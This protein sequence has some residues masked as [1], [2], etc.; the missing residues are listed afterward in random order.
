MKTCIL[1]WTIL[2]SGPH[3]FQACQAVGKLCCQNIAEDKARE[4]CTFLGFTGRKRST[5]ASSYD[6]PDKQL[7]YI[8]L[9]QKHVIP[10]E[11]LP[12]GNAP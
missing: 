11:V 9:V 12:T 2:T 8:L 5:A 1:I 10:I 3:G 4:S 7:Q 6:S